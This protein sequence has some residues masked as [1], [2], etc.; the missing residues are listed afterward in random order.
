MQRRAFSVGQTVTVAFSL[1]VGLGRP[2]CI[3]RTETPLIK[4]TS[5]EG[6]TSHAF[7]ESLAVSATSLSEDKVDMRLGTSL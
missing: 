4:S 1:F 6:Y 3:S 7:R 2:L 5:A